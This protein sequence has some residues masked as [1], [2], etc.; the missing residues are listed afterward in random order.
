MTRGT[1]LYD[2]R[3]MPLVL[4]NGVLGNPALRF[5]RDR[6]GVHRD[7]SGALQVSVQSIPMLTLTTTEVTAYGQGTGAAVV[8]LRARRATASTADGQESSLE[9]YDGGTIGGRLSVYRESFANYGFKWYG[10]DS[11]SGGLHTIPAMTLTSTKRLGLGTVTPSTTLHVVAD[12]HAPAFNLSTS[13]KAITTPGYMQISNHAVQASADRFLQWGLAAAPNQFMPGSLAGD[14]AMMA[15]NGRLMLAGQSQT[16]L[17]LDNS[18]VQFMQGLTE[19]A[20]IDNIGNFSLGTTGVGWKFHMVVPGAGNGLMVTAPDA[21]SP[22][23]PVVQLMNAVASPTKMGFMGL[24][25]VAGHFGYGVESGDVFISTAGSPAGRLLL[26]VASSPRVV[27]TPTTVQVMHSANATVPVLTVGDTGL[28]GSTIAPGSVD[29]PQLADGAVTTAKLD[30]PVVG[31]ENLAFHAVHMAAHTYSNSGGAVSFPPNVWTAIPG[32]VTP[33]F[34][35]TNTHMWLASASVACSHSVA[36]GQ[37]VLRLVNILTSGG[38]PTGTV[39]QLWQGTPSSHGLANGIFSVSF[40][41]LIAQGAWLTSLFRVEAF[42]P[43]PGTVTVLSGGTFNFW[44][45]GR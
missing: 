44:E 5:G 13:T 32:L 16:K 30:G 17:I 19:L 37:V 21:A 28:L 8:S 18:V 23:S 27:I 40:S 15:V 7:P 29:T 34:N 43:S 10:R 33:S 39:T 35:P 6:S 24:A 45:V 22:N 9:L 25:Q 3:S 11:A 26:G 38:L 4:P 2:R 14:S 42:S 12:F 20:R 41:A 36:G 31:T 1:T